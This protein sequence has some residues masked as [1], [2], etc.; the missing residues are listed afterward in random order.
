VVGAPKDFKV[1]KL[2]GDVKPGGTL[3]GRITGRR[4]KTSWAL[5]FDVNLPSKDAAAGMTCS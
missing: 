3:A 2:A 1:E 5:D 4:A